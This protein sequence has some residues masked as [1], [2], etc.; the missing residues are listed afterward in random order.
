MIPGLVREDVGMGRFIQLYLP[1]NS[2]VVFW[3]LAFRLQWWDYLIFHG[4][5]C[6]LFVCRS[7]L[8]YFAR[9]GRF[10]IYRDAAQ[11]R[12]QVI[13]TAPHIRR[14]DEIIRLAFCILGRNRHSVNG[15]HC[16]KIDVDSIVNFKRLYSSSQKRCLV[17]RYR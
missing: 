4:V 13:H 8:L 9:C 16:D 7:I 5:V 2:F 6:R 11:Q 14:S 1:R 3:R 15:S 10:L 17:D 12:R